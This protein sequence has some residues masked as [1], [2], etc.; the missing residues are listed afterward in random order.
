MIPCLCEIPEDIDTL[1]ERLHI[2]LSLGERISDTCYD[3]NGERKL[4]AVVEQNMLK[5]E[6]DLPA[7]LLTVYTEAVLEKAVINGRDKAVK[8]QGNRYVIS[9]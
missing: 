8:R 9:E 1:W 2:I 7:V 3:D 5:V 4:E 6:T